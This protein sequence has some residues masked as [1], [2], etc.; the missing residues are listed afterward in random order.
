MSEECYS[1]FEED[2]LNGDGWDFSRYDEDPAGYSGD[3]AGEHF[4]SS[5]EFYD[6]FDRHYGIH[7]VENGL[8]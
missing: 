3:I 1:L 5:E 6:I 2:G 7:I 4:D 8:E